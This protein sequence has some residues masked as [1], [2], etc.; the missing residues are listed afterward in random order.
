MVTT[1]IE[2]TTLAKPE[3]INRNWFLVDAS[4]L[5]LGRL[6]CDL[7]TILMGKHKAIYTPHVDTGDF[8]VVINAEK[9]KVTGK[10]LQQEAHDYYTYYPGGHKYVSWE[11]LL[12]KHPERLIELAVKRML[13][14]T[15]LGRAMYKKL[16]VY[17][18]SE[19]KHQAQ[20]PVSLDLSEGLKKGLQKLGAD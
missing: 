10:K 13:P 20:K 12:E 11:K 4:G 5:V 9:I 18:G 16:K 15:R 1:L 8:I 6:A 7:A 2:K 14:K 17:R 3:Q 19:H